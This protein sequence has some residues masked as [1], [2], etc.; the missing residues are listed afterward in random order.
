[1]QQSPLPPTDDT[2]R[3]EPIAVDAES[4]AAIFSSSLRT[5]RRWDAM[6]RCPR[7]FSLGKKRLWRLSDL[8]AWASLGFPRRSDFERLMAER[9]ENSAAQQ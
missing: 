6:G 9:E 1:M 8:R 3:V 2:K 5:Y 7:G 4:A